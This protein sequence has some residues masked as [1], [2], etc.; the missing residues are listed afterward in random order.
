MTTDMETD[1]SFWAH[2]EETPTYK[3]MFEKLQRQTSDIKENYTPVFFSEGDLCS[4]Q[5]SEDGSWY[6]GR[7]VGSKGQEVRFSIVCRCGH[8]FVPYSS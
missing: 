8:Y 7:I 4:A 2:L 1:G 5:F 6:R 3:A